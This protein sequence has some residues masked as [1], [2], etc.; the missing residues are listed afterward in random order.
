MAIADDVDVRGAGGRRVP[1]AVFRGVTLPT[2]REGAEDD[3]EADERAPERL[4]SKRGGRVWPGAREREDR[5]RG[6]RAGP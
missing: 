1:V 6:A 3:R 2:E 5:R 4:G